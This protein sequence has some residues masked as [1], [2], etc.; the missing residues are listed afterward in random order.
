VSCSGPSYPLRH[1]AAQVSHAR[2]TAAMHVLLLLT[3]VAASNNVTMPPALERAAKAV[4]RTARSAAFASQPDLA[5]CDK[6][7]TP[8]QAIVC[9]LAAVEAQ[10]PKDATAQVAVVQDALTLGAALGGMADEAGPFRQQRFDAHRRTCSVALGLVRSLQASAHDAAVT[11]PLRK[12]A[13]SCVDQ[14]MTFGVAANASSAEQAQVQALATTHQCFADKALSTKRSSG[15]AA[16]LLAGE[17]GKQ[18][19]QN[20]DAVRGYALARSLDVKR[21]RDKVEDKKGPLDVAKLEACVCSAVQRWKLPVT[22]PTPVRVPLVDDTL[23]ASLTPDATGAVKSCG[24]L[25][26]S[27]LRP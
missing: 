21:C 24:A 17:D 5:T 1:S 12:Q 11:G 14:A 18:A 23:T 16:A 25:Q 15:P 10:P 4:P 2:Y 7:T 20:N 13:C 19:L 22:S 26:G 27:A 9:Q 3:V 6:P 8:L